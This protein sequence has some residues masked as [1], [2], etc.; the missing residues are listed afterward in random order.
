LKKFVEKENFKILFSGFNKR[1]MILVKIKSLEKNE[2]RPKNTVFGSVAKKR[3]ILFFFTP[4]VS[5]KFTKFVK[6]PDFL[7]W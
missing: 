4:A 6:G 3:K 7:I 1:F 5:S 2:V